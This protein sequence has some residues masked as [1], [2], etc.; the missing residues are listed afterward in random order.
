MTAGNR[1]IVFDT[2]GTLMDGRVA[3]LDAVAEALIATYRHFDLQ[4]VEPDRERI[5]LAMGLPAPLFFRSA[6][7]PETVPS[8]LRHPFVAEFE[9]KSSRAEVAALHRGESHL[10]DGAEETLATLRQRGFDLALYSN[11]GEPYFQAVIAV[12][13]LDRWFSRTLSLEYAARRRLARDKTGMVGH[14]SRD[15]DQVVVVGD[16]HHDIEA[17]QAAG[18]VTVGCRFG[19]GEDDELEEADWRIDALTDLLELPCLQGSRRAA[20]G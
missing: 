7:D 2:D 16:R 20:R 17:G 9:V 18:A 8:D 13:G 5:G 10:Y 19:F 15:Y 12:H 1:V 3:V 14:L 6:Y 4:G 11:A